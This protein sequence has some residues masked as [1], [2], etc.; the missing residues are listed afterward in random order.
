V[1]YSAVSAET[2]L[3]VAS[4]GRDASRADGENSLN[5]AAWNSLVQI[6]QPFCQNP[7]DRIGID[8]PA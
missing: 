4:E 2:A 6:A 7:S 3:T 8:P 1:N 5:L